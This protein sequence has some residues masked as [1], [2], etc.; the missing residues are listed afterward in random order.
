MPV[1][2][3]EERLQ[4]SPG[5]RP[6]LWPAFIP[7]GMHCGVALMAHLHRA[8]TNL[9]LALSDPAVTRIAD[10]IQEEHRPLSYERIVNAPSR[11][12]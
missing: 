4:F 12:R 6:P 2:N 10:I 3:V 7:A 8:G 5:Q 11:P 1:R 9:L